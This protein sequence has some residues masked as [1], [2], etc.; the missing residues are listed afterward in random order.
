MDYLRIGLGFIRIVVVPLIVM[1]RDNGNVCWRVGYGEE[2]ISNLF[3]N[4]FL[5]YTRGSTWSP[6]SVERWQ[7]LAAA[8]L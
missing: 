1:H 6:N 2:R 3:S 4:Q 8:R 5:L 7:A